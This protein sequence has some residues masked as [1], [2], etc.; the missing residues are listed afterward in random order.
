MKYCECGKEIQNGSAQCE[1]CYK[2]SIR[3][4][5]DRPSI[6]ILLEELSKSNYTMVG[7]KYGV[8]DN[9]IR[10]WLK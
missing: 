2:I 5:K 10:K 8:S 6:E 1:T 7:K 9:T 4:V 3:K